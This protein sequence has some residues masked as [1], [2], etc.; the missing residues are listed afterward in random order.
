[1]DPDPAGDKANHTL[2][3]LIA[4]TDPIYQS[5]LKSDSKG[6]REDYMVGNREEL[7]EKT[8]EEMKWEADEEIAHA[9]CLAREA[10]R[11]KRHNG[12]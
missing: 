9:A 8:V 5:S 1:M 6:G 10:E 11:G 12:L 2:A 3:V 4:T 7:L